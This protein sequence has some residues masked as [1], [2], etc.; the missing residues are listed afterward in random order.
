MNYS[1]SSTLLVYWS[2]LSL[3]KMK[4]FL[5]LPSQNKQTKQNSFVAW[6][7]LSLQLIL[8]FFYSS[9]FKRIASTDSLCVQFSIHCSLALLP[10]TELFPP[11]SPVSH[12][13]QMLAA[14]DLLI[15]VWLSWPIFSFLKCSFPR[16][17]YAFSDS[18][19]TY[20]LAFNNIFMFPYLF[21]FNYNYFFKE[22][23]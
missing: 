17:Y 20:P 16:T 5:P 23:W 21:S 11:S 10:S 4:V 7:P 6:P 2:F 8:F 15:R 18:L 1:F 14:F 12:Q 9:A 13:D 19:A 22:I 3:F